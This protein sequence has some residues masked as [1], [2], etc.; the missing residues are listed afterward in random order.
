MADDDFEPDSFANAPEAGL[1][2]EEQIGT[3]L[4][5]LTEET[6][7]RGRQLLLSKDEDAALDPVE[8]VMR[9]NPSL[10]EEEAIR[11]MEAFGG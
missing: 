1:T 3:P 7:E 8:A 11:M 9:R 4:S 2:D 10:T 6:L 5:A